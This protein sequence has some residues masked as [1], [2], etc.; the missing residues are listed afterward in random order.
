MIRPSGKNI[1][2]DYDELGFAGLH[3]SGTPTPPPPPL[4]SEC[5]IIRRTNP[6]PYSTQHKPKRAVSGHSHRPTPAGASKHSP[7]ARRP[8]WRC[9]FAPFRSPRDPDAASGRQ[10]ACVPV[11]DSA[12]LLFGSA[13]RSEWSPQRH[14]IADQPSHRSHHR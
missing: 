13:V 2:K 1:D 8:R 3:V 12:R 4:N 10:R 6:L 5:L 14:V 7:A 9:R 11:A